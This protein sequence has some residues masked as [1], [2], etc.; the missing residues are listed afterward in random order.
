MRTAESFFLFFFCKEQKARGG[1][2]TCLHNEINT[3]FRRL[4]PQTV[5]FFFPPDELLL[6]LL[7][8][9]LE[10]YIIDAHPSTTSTTTKHTDEKRP[11]D[12]RP[13]NHTTT[14]T[15]HADPRGG[16]RLLPWYRH[17]PARRRPVSVPEEGAPRWLPP[18]PSS[19]CSGLLA[20][21]RAHP[22]RRGA[23]RVNYCAAERGEA[24]RGEA[25]RRRRGE[26]GRRRGGE[27]GEASVINLA[28]A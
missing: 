22:A 7:L 12:A 19:Y 26:E 9:E 11:K 13:R 20:A 27:T 4:Y 3:Q 21:A 17:S 5:R 10:P 1:K 16:P 28:K 15:R 2:E 14:K 18:T 6:L 25:I 23:A 8:P 24:R